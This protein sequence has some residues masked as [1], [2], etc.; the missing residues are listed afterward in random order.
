MRFTI[1]PELELFAESVRGALADW[2]APV[3]PVF[4]EWQD[5][6][7]DALAARLAEIGWAELWG[8]PELLGPAVA[9]G[10]ELGRACAPLCLV[11]EAT[12]GAPLALGGRVRHGVGRVE[13]GAREPTLDGTGTL[14]G[15]GSL[16]VTSEPARLHVW[17]VVT[18]AYLAGVAD[19]ALEKAVEHARSREQFGAALG[20]LPAVQA[21]L[22]DAAMARD[23]LLLSAWSAADSEAGF[24]RDSLAWA[25]SACRE[26]TAHVQQVHGGIGFA[27]EGGVHRYYRR[28]KSVQVWTDALLRELGSLA[29]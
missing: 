11:D 13:G 21:H 28:A 6:R 12:L 4:G 20:A 22:A 19:G 7:D 29:L 24:A 25:G 26:V 3:E 27:L 5:D 16:P 18:L 14:R 9:G 23:G 8:D 10:V 2:E 15:V 1:E 17:G